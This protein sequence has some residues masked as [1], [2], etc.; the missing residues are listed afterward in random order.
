MFL[1]QASCAD[2][3]ISNIGAD[4]KKNSRKLKRIF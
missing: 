2:H 1:V 4:D 3:F